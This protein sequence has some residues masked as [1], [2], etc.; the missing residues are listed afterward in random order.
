MIFG[1]DH[2]ELLK[3][4]GAFFIAT[5]IKNYKQKLFA[6]EFEVLQW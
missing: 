6:D 2:Q 4:V 5:I 3:M 1:P